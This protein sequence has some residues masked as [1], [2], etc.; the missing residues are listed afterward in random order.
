MGKKISQLNQATTIDGT[1]K[2]ALVQSS[3]TK[4]ATVNEISNYIVPTNLTVSASD[5]IDLGS[6]TYDNTLLFKLT[7]S[8]STG[9][10][11]LTLPDATATENLNRIIR[12]ISDTTFSS[13]TH[14]DLTPASGQTLDGSSSAYRI[15]KE[16]EGVMCWCDGSEW[17]I[18]QKKA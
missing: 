14:A 11:V 7:W 10:M 8:G 18:I 9:T 15:N 12:V 3:E 4:Y 16:Y 1:E 13:S 17:F 6:T 2:F 5:T